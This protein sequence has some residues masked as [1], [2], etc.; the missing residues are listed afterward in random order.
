[1]FLLNGLPRWNNPLFNIDAFERATQDR[2]FLCIEAAD[3]QFDV[4]VTRSFLITLQPAAIYAVP[5]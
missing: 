5:K 2:F 3:K 1:M 4:N